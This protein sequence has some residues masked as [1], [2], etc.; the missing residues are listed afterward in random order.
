MAKPGGS[1]AEVE[2]EQTQLFI[3]KLQIPST[4]IRPNVESFK[5][6]RVTQSNSHVPADTNHQGVTTDK[7]SPTDFHSKVVIRSSSDGFE[8]IKI[9]VFVSVLMTMANVA[10]LS[11]FYSRSSSRNSMTL[12]NG[13]HMIKC[14][15]RP[16][17]PSCFEMQ[18]FEGK[19]IYRS[20]GR[21][22]VLAMYKCDASAEETEHHKCIGEYV[23]TH[24]STYVW[25]HRLYL[26]RLTDKYSLISGPHAKDG[27]Q[28]YPRV[29]HMLS[30]PY[31]WII[32]YDAIP[33][34][35]FPESSLFVKGKVIVEERLPQ[36]MG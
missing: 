17:D 22:R 21:E 28:V 1:P 9:L 16:S 7:D 35:D 5:R 29:R 27:R 11:I 6:D 13:D 36:A 20:V 3:G 19:T 15:D 25:F 33:F 34:D 30:E 26:D 10:C 31:N 2:A 14:S 24:N 23:F 8:N 4:G 32:S 18:D 12:P